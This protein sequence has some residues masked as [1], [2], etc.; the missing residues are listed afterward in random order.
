MG[1]E[2]KVK[3]CASCGV[4]CAGEDN[5]PVCGEPCPNDAST[6]EAEEEMDEDEDV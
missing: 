4:D 6:D 5:C 2:T 1:D 3:K